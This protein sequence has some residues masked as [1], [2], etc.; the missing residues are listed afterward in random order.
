MSRL[1]KAIQLAAEVHAGQVDK[2][3]NPYILHP[4]RV[5]CAVEKD[6]RSRSNDFKEDFLCAAVLHDVIEDC[7]YEKYDVDEI[8]TLVLNTIGESCYFTIDSLS[9]KY[10]QAWKFYIE[11][12]YNDPIA[13]FV[14]IR[15]LEDNCDLSRMI[16]ITQDDI[17][18]NSMYLRAKIY[19]ETGKGKL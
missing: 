16:T 6:L 17:N 2:G 4:L 13:R 19:L 7:D 10:N 1:D 3:G 9:R 18:R 15:D 5:M 14:K 11:T 8:N 12:V